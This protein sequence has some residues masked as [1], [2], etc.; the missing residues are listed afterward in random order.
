M[1]L[2][3]CAIGCS[4]FLGLSVALRSHDQ[5]QASHW[6]IWENQ[7]IE[8]MTETYPEYPGILN[9][10][11]L[12]RTFILSSFYEQTGGSP[13]SYNSSRGLKQLWSQTCQGREIV[14][15]R[16]GERGKT[17][18][19]RDNMISNEFFKTDIQKGFDNKYFV[20]LG[21]LVSQKIFQSLVL[22][23]LRDVLM[24]SPTISCGYGVSLH[25][26]QINCQTFAPGAK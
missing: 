24:P 17:K 12:P 9:I 2:F 4:F 3:V 11:N 23:I 19:G 13:G 18:T 6:S 20:P 21:C 7:G 26:V 22:I 8:G 14:P 5:F 16:R 25:L 1:C 15:I 10:I